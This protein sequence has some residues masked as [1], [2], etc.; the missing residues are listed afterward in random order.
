M[1]SQSVGP[2]PVPEPV[3]PPRRNWRV[4][5]LLLA[6][7]LVVVAFLAFGPRRTGNG[8]DLR[9][10]ARPRVTDYAW[11]LRDLDGQPVDFAEFRG[12]PVFVNLWASWCPPCRAEMPS[13]GRLSKAAHDRAPG[14][15]IVLIGVN[16]T[17]Q[18]LRRFLDTVSKDFQPGIRFLVADDVPTAFESDGIPATFVIGP[19]GRFLVEQ[20]GSAEW[21]TPEVIDYL[22]KLSASP[23]EKR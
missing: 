16:D 10:P 5:V 14:V 13:I 19:D 12:K 4:I 18:N 2:E 21:D 20:I 1:D 22:A 11:S 6:A 15:E 8:P 23:V 9:G 17:P 3:A 7:W